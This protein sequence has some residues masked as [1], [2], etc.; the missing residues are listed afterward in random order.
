MEDYFGR[1]I[2]CE[3]EVRKMRNAALHPDRIALQRRDRFLSCFSFEYELDGSI[4]F[5]LPE[6]VITKTVIT[7]FKE[8]FKLSNFLRPTITDADNYLIDAA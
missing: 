5:E 4:C 6:C 7:N 2:L 1:I 3:D 8:F